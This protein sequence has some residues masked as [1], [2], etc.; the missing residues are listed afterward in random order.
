M[1]LFAPMRTRKHCL[2]GA[3]T[4]ALA[5]TAAG[6]PLG[7]GVAGAAEP[8]QEWDGLQLR[9]SKNVDRLYL[10]PGAS[11]AGYKKVRLEPLQ[12]EFD[13]NWDPNRSRVGTS[14]L[15]A[16]DFEKIKK[17][18][19]EAFAQ[20]SAEEL[21]KGGYDL[22]KAPG[23]DVLDITPFIMNLYIVAPDKQTA[24]R[25]RTYTS[26]AGQM[27]LVAEMRDSDTNTILARVVDNQRMGSSVN[28]RITTSVTNLGDAK[29]IIIGWASALRHAL[30]V[31]NGKPG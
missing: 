11:L 28:W 16:T 20:V 4:V 30:D 29:R 10:R 22:V 13:K 1:P 18:L 23:D 8:P 12:V 3:L 5:I 25:S 26:E 31:A 6:V 21:K 17:T 24:G 15:T 7:V 19:A 14:R 9:D 27:T 2:V